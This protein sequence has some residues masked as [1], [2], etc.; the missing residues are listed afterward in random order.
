M[1]VRIGLAIAAAAILAA[2]PNID[3]QRASLSTPVADTPDARECVI[4]GY[5]IGTS[6]HDY[7]V[8][9]ISRRVTPEEYN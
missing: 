4:M 5:R 2:C 6:R 8:Q 3:G 7:C 9:V 1:T